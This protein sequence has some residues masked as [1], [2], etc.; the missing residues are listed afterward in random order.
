MN[1]GEEFSEAEYQH[2]WALALDERRQMIQDE[3]TP[4]N[5]KALLLY[6]QGQHLLEA[7]DFN[8][9]IASFDQALSLQPN[10]EA[11][12][13]GRATALLT[14]GEPEAAIENCNRALEIT[15]NDAQAWSLRGQAL[16]RQKRYD[17]A[18]S[19]CDRALDLDPENPHAWKTLSEALYHLGRYDEAIVSYDKAL[20]L[21][22][23]D[24]KAWGDR[25]VA[26]QKLGRYDEAI[27]SYDKRLE[28][29]PDNH[30]LWH[31]RGLA[32][33]RLHR[34]EAAIANFDR[35]LSLK[36]DFY[37]ATRSKL[38]VLLRTGQLWQ[39]TTGDV[40]N[41]QPLLNDLSN[42]FEAFVKTKLPALVVI[43]LVVLSST[44]DRGVSLAISAVF[45]L[46]TV[47][48]DLISESR[49]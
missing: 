16:H 23:D 41:R 15:P 4:K 44:H 1:R 7:K 5:L 38:F 29:E 25:G 35:A 31:Q 30:H 22:P 24:S 33:R 49:R 27:A 36:P 42:V 34:F 19:S 28:A 14:A 40:A 46:I 8:A 11:A 13:I 48:G 9:A 39:Y 26:L 10:Y 6:Q 18:A 3:Q 2:Y 47:T 20:T 43:A 32:L 45:L 12:W 17:E 37:A 21:Q